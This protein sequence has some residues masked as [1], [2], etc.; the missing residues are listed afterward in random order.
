MDLSY[1]NPELPLSALKAPFSADKA[2]R[3]V[4]GHCLE[5]I[6]LNAGRMAAGAYDDEHIHQ[7]RV[8]LRRLRSALDLFEGWAALPESLSIAPLNRLFR[9]LGRVRDQTVLR[10]SLARLL[11]EA[12]APPLILPSP[13]ALPDPALRVRTPKVQQALLQLMAFVSQGATP[14]LAA[15]HGCTLDLWMAQRLARWHRHIQREGRRFAEL[16]ESRR[17][18]LRKRVKTLR[19]GVEF[20]AALFPP[21]EVTRYL[22]AVRQIQD[23]LGQYVDL[24]LALKWLQDDLPEAPESAFALDWLSA[25][26]ETQRHTCAGI[27]AKFEKIHPLR[28]S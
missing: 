25:R 14:L 1:L 10:A 17:H 28:L 20:V 15:P 23:S 27:L 3:I 9:D 12:G 2:L 19:Y 4:L 22:K 8:G 11:G 13:K 6:I 7:L 18:A 16:P 24:S 26:R 21:R 5:P